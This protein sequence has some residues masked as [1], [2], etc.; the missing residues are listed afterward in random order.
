MRVIDILP[1]SFKGIKWT[2]FSNQTPFLMGAF[3]F[4]NHITVG[5][6]GVGCIREDMYG[7]YPTR[8]SPGSLICQWFCRGVSRN[9]NR[10]SGQLRI[11]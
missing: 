2:K 10:I 1:G 3:T 6:L 5:S 9:P 4:F 8:A 7:Y 11:F